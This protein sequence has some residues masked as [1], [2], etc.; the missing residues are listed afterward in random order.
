MPRA[1]TVAADAQLGGH[2]TVFHGWRIV[3]AFAVTQTVGYGL[4]FGIASLAAP[5]LLADRYSITLSPSLISRCRSRSR[6]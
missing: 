1:E 3:A 5:A 6:R 4:G 2:R